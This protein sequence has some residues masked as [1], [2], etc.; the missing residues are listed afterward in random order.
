MSN[1]MKTVNLLLA[2]LVVLMGIISA[3]LLNFGDSLLTNRT[4]VYW[5]MGVNIALM[6]YEL[7]TVFIIEKKRETANPRQLVN[8][9][10]GLK[11]IRLLLSLFFVVV[12]YFAVGEEMKRFAMVFVVIYLVYLLFDTMYLAKGEKK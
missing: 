10:M 8:M 6:L 9:Y 7:M 11:V 2:I 4:P 12:Y 3:I 1:S 5:L